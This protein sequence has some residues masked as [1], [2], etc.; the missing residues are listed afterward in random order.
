MKTLKKIALNSAKGLLLL[1]IMLCTGLYFFQERLI[2]FPRQLSEDFSFSFEAPFEEVR[3]PVEESDS[4]SALWFHQDSS[5]GLVFYLHGNAGALDGWGQVAP[6]Y[7]SLG[8]DVFLLDYRGFGKSTGNI[9]SEAQ[10]LEDVQQAY[11]WAK[12]KY[13][14]QEI[15]LIGY[16]IGTGSAAYLAANNQPKQL[17]LKAP[18]YSLVDMMQQHYAIIPTFLLKYRFETHT[19]LPRIKAPITIFHGNQDAV[20]PLHSSLRLKEFLKPTDQIIVLPN[21]GHNGMNSNPDYLK[22]LVT[23]L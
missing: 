6:T 21:A 1:Y 17:L 12:T 10:F 16:S 18:Y 4:L 3:I 15:T 20:I 5:K 9:Y 23:L 14:E 11:N 8:Y 7:L 13:S 19:Y 22:T 2:F